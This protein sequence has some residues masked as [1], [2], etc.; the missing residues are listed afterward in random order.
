MYNQVCY[1][2]VLSST[3]FSFNLHQFLLVKST[4]QHIQELQMKHTH[5][6]THTESTC[7]YIRIECYSRL[8]LQYT[9]NI[10]EISW[11]FK[12][13]GMWM[14]CL[15]ALVFLLVY[16]NYLRGLPILI[17]IRNMYWYIEIYSVYMV[18]QIIFNFKK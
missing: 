4:D 18:Y 2:C 14:H 8:I 9:E 15:S 13:E 11:L 17:Q 10:S 16:A 1:Y 5:T 7:K 6:H 12:W 3:K